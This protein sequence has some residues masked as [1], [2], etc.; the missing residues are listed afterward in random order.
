[1]SCLVLALLDRVAVSHCL[2]AIPTTHIPNAQ[3]HTHPH[4]YIYIYICIYVHTRYYH[5]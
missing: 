1:M 5:Y 2:L 4:T 3:M